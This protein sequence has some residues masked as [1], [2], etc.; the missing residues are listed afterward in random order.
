M[1][2]AR[3]FEPYISASMGAPKTNIPCTAWENSAYADFKLADLEDG[4]N[5]N[6][7]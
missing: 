3:N 1:I 7:R 5:R 4:Y 2:L 6:A